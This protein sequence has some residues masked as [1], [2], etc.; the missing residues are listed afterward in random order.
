MTDNNILEL[1]VSLARNSEIYQFDLLQAS[2]LSTYC[3]DKGL[4]L[5]GDTAIRDI[6]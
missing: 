5:L 4:P 1:R 2:E 3:H 6:W